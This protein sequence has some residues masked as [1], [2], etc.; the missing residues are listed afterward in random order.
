MVDRCYT[1]KV[2]FAFSNTTS[3]LALF[4]QSH[5]PIMHVW[6]RRS[7][8]PL[9]LACAIDDSKSTGLGGVERQIGYMIA[10]PQARERV[11]AEIYIYIYS[12]LLFYTSL[13]I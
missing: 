8:P 5:A 9:C 3:T 4:F 1:H 7:P 6:L 2:F 11:I 10:I 12:L 13:L